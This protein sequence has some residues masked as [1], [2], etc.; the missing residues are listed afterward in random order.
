MKC[1]NCENEGK[2]DTYCRI[3]HSKITESAKKFIEVF[4]TPLK[5]ILIN[6]IKHGIKNFHRIKAYQSRL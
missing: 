1:A 4:F 5:T 6:T 3:K 2:S